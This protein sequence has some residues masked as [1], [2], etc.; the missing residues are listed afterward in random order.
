MNDEQET[1]DVFARSLSNVGLEVPKRRCEAL[2]E[3]PYRKPS[4]RNL[5]G[6]TWRKC[7]RVA[8][9]TSMFGKPLCKECAK[10]LCE[11]SNA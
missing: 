11:T 5:S 9:I 6:T 7:G 2:R 10:Q 3:Q 1:N 8:T 4:G